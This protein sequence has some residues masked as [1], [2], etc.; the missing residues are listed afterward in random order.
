MICGFLKTVEISIL[1]KKMPFSNFPTL[2][3][4]KHL[5]KICTEIL[6]EKLKN[7]FS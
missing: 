3:C 2:S 1:L 4:C 5:S 7:I 6:L